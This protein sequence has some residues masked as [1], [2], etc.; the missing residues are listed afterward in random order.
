MDEFKYSENPINDTWKMILKYSY[1]SNIEK[2]LGESSD[3]EFN[4][5]I[6]GSI[7][8]SSEYF[9]SFSKVSLNTSP[10]LLYYGFVNLLFASSSMITKKNI[11]IKNHGLSI[12]LPDD[13]SNIGDC[14]INI[15]NS[16][17]GAYN[18]YNSIHSKG[19]NYPQKIKIKDI[20][21]MIPELKHDFEECYSQHSLCLPIEIIKRREGEIERIKINELLQDLSSINIVD[22]DKSYLQPQKTNKYIILRKKLNGDDIGTKSISGQKFLY[23]YFKSNSK[24]YEFNEIMIYFIG[25]F[26]FGYISR[27][28]PEIWY[29]FVQTD[30]TGEKSLVEDFLSLAHRILPNLILNKIHNKR[31]IFTNNE[32]GMVDKTTQY[33]PE[34]VKKIIKE[35]MRGRN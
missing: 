13:S 29:P 3:K 18:I 5:S 35:E 11:I 8:Q 21:S 14:I 28:H 15:S 22:Y 27:Y 34:D 16:N 19:S 17:D 26:A 7:V 23:Q 4:Q 1:T 12:T 20:F 30:Q 25:L 10:L 33:D 32:I 31:I 2:Y 9:S 24:D 6:A